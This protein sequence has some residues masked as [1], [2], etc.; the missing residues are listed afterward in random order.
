MLRHRLRRGGGDRRLHRLGVGGRARRGL[1]HRAADLGGQARERV[2]WAHRAKRRLRHRNAVGLLLPQRGLVDGETRG[3]LGAQRMRLRRRGFGLGGPGGGVAVS[4]GRA[5][6][7]DVGLHHHVG[8][9]ADHQEMLDVVAAD[10]DELP[11]AVDVG[12]I[13]HRKARLAAAGG[14]VDAGRAEAPHQPGGGADQHQH[15]HECNDEIH[16]RR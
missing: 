11:A 13:D 15:D 7:H 5:R 2:G 6:A 12:G 3:A 10:D 14:G 16:R 1:R 8:R 4:R 9:P